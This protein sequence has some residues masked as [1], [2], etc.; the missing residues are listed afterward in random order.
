MRWFAAVIPAI[1]V[2]GE[3]FPAAIAT[4]APAAAGTTGAYRISE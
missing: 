1:S 3:D 2:L 4:D